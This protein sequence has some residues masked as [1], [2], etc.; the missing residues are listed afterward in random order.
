LVTLKPGRERKKSEPL[1]GNASNKE[2]LSARITAMKKFLIRTER[3][4]SGPTENGAINLPA[5]AAARAA[6]DA[7]RCAAKPALEAA[8]KVVRGNQAF[9]GSTGGRPPAEYRENCDFRDK[10]AGEFA[11]NTVLRGSSAALLA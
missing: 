7:R 10:K 4:C 2:S 8:V 1:H 6:A 3:V 11:A 5:A 9:V